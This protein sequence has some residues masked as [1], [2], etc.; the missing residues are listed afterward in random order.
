MANFFESSS[1]SNRLLQSLRYTIATADN[2]EAYANVLDLNATE[3]YTQQNYVPSS[4]LPYSGSSQHLEFIT[5]SIG[6]PAEDVNIAQYYYRVQMTRSDRNLGNSKSQAWLAISGS[7]YDP[8]GES[9]DTQLISSNQL[10]DWLSN[11]YATPS[12][13]ISNAEAPTP[14]YNVS[15]RVNGSA[16]T[17]GWQFDY[18]TGVLQF[19]SE[20]DAPAT[21]ATVLV[22]GYRYVGQTL[23]QFVSSS[24][25]GTGAGFPFS[26][27]AVITGSLLI[28]GSSN[29][30]IDLIVSGGLEVT[31]GI[32]GSNA[33][34]ST[35]TITTL[36]GTDATF[37]TLTVNTF[38]S[39]STLIT[40]GSNIFGDTV[41]LNNLTNSTQN[42]FNVTGVT[43]GAIADVKSSNLNVTA[44]FNFTDAT[45]LAAE[46]TLVQAIGTFAVGNVVTFTSQSLGAATGGGTD[47]TLTLIQ[48]N[49]SSND[50]QTLIG[51]NIKI[52]GSTGINGNL[53]VDGTLSITGFSDVSASLA[54]ATAGTGIFDQVGTTDIYKTDKQLLISSSAPLMATPY[55]GSN[56]TVANDGTDGTATK[57]SVVTSQSGWFYNHN[58]GVPKSKAWGTDL[59]GSYFNNFNHNT[60]TS[61]ILRFIAG[62]LKD[63]APDVQPNT[64]TFSRVDID[65][66]ANAGQ[67]APNVGF[68]P[69]GY[70]TGVTNIT[71]DY[72]FSKGFATPGK[73]I[74]HNVTGNPYSDANG[75]SRAFQSI[76]AGTTTVSSS[77]NTELFGLGNI[78]TLFAV[79]SSA[80]WKYADNSTKTDINTNTSSSVRIKATG[81]GLSTVSEF[82]YAPIPTGNDL[83]SPTFQDGLFGNA[84]NSGKPGIF[85]I[86]IAD[87][88]GETG[89]P[90]N[91]TGNASIGY[92]QLTSSI[93]VD[94]NNTSDTSVDEVEIFY[95]PM[96]TINSAFTPAQT[97]SYTNTSL[98]ALTMTS[99]SLG[100]APYVK[101]ATWK[102][103]AQVN[104][105]FS[106]LY[107][108]GTSNVVSTTAAGVSITPSSAGVG[109]RT[110][111][112]N[113]SGQVTTADVLFDST[114]TSARGA[115]T[116]P[117]ID[118]VAIVTQSIAF[119]PTTSQTNIAQG[120]FGNNNFTVT[121]T[122]K[123]PSGTSI[124]AG[125]TNTITGKYFDTSN[126]FGNTNPLDN[127]DIMAYFGGSETD[128]AGSNQNSTEAFKSDVFRKKINDNLLPGNTADDYSNGGYEG[129]VALAAA[130]LQVKPGFLVKPGGSNGYWLISNAGITTGTQ[131]G[132]A[133]FYAREF[134][135]TGTNSPIKLLKFDFGVTLDADSTGNVSKWESPSNNS[136]SVLVYRKS[137]NSGN[138]FVDL[139]DYAG[140][141]PGSQSTNTAQNPF[142]SSI[143]VKSN[144]NSSGTQSS[145]TGG[146]GLGQ[147]TSGQYYLATTATKFQQMNTNDILGV[148]IRY[149]GDP[150]TVIQSIGVQYSTGA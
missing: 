58:V 24:S 3:V 46:P 126:P 84:G 117:T 13:A 19:T 70:Q 107:A 102:S 150:S 85:P 73:A 90:A 30:P 137:N 125:T 4:S 63:Q 50:T 128:Q 23:D 22:S 118:D 51:S 115:N 47:L 110:L 149:N 40:S 119:A 80:T 122:S 78:G 64:R 59:D 15:V 9:T 145:P 123:I 68:I 66:E 146:G 28:S 96:S 135:Y 133:R 81:S 148:L 65:D 56:P 113:A 34:F 114:G 32:T 106:P 20:A 36:T 92:Y 48:S 120:G 52:T 142:G 45:T 136:I 53:D 31:E 139:A 121:T 1:K 8:S 27:S 98:T 77:A 112:T 43:P 41:V 116:V 131:S 87:P 111:S 12:L 101:G 109:Q 100:R 94:Y 82:I 16:V 60:D 91:L 71:Y 88:I 18:K 7:G 144:A 11:K 38:I 2:T 104:N 75:Y 6:I 42:S 62:L 132:G 129:D 143:D 33:N 67:T 14:G 103:G 54:S 79:S 97:V 76:A 72:L 74:F 21:T 138:I 39:S 26:G 93:K 17:S 10:T 5:A 95:A 108:G 57:Y 49:L 141:D 37:D 55:S 140:S 134:K 25:D 29:E 86:S 83:I 127:A 44:S 35:G 147:A 105:L 89:F 61:E 124:I 130:D 69:Q 99:R